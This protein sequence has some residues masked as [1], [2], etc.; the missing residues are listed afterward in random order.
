MAKVPQTRDELENH[1]KEQLAFLR[2][3]AS[4]YDAGFKGEAKRLAVVARVLLHDTANSK[5]LLGQLA[6]KA[7]PFCDTSYDFDPDKY[8]HSFHGLAMMRVGTA[9]GGEFIPRCAAPPKPPP[10]EPL[11]WVRFEQWWGR[12]VIVDAQAN[13]FTREGLVLALSNKEGG[14]HVDPQLDPAWAALTRQSSMA[15]AWGIAGKGG[16]FTGVEVASMRQIAHELIASL[17]KGCPQL[18]K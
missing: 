10:W 7:I 18:F 12:V 15:L 2:A 6:L 9:T 11:K 14:A 8:F 1:L 16:D 13:Q 17:E 5:S 4:S 3:S